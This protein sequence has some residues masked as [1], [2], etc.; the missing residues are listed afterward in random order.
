MT[1]TEQLITR[2]H[3]LAERMGRAPSTISARV[4]GGGQVL[5]D[6]ES[7]KT[8]TL[9]KYQRAKV[10]LDQLEAEAGQGKAA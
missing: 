2:L 6:L 1:E 4:L 3:A 8:I 5:S 10:L 7:G 9:A